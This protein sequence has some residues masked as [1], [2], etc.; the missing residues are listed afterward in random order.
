MPLRLHSAAIFV[1]NMDRALLFY[2]DH[3]G[4]PVNRQGS[5]GAEFL[6][7]ETVLGVHPAVH[8]ESRSMVGRHTGLTFHTDDV[9]GLCE[10]LRQRGVTLVAEPSQTGFGIM[11]LVADPDGNV[12]ALWEDKFPGGEQ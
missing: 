12:L 9:V 3:L 4:L 8:P 10:R 7:G 1:T 5:F 2:R 6:D 11:A